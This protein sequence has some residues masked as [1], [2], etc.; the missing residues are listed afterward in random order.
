MTDPLMTVCTKHEALETKIEEM[1]GK[2]DR[3]AGL[4]EESIEIHKARAET[5]D[6]RIRLVSA[7]M[8]LALVLTGMYVRPAVSE[9]HMFNVAGYASCAWLFGVETINLWNRGV[10]KKLMRRNGSTN[11][12][13]V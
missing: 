11:G 7:V 3:L 1:D 12:N 9:I 13:G 10:E 5:S 4:L 8:L 2:I 6:H